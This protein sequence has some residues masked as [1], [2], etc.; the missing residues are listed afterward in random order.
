M[1]SEILKRP[2]QSFVRREGRMT[3][4]QKK[5]FETY[6]NQYGIE[7]G[8]GM[9]D[10]DIVFGR[11]SLRTL[12]IGFGNGDS[13]LEQAQLNSERDFI[14]IEVYRSGI[15]NLLINCEK[16]NV[17]N[18]RVINGD[19]VEVLQQHIFNDSLDRIQ[20]FFPDPWPKERHHKRRLI[21]ENFIDL[22]HEKLMCR[23]QLHLATDWQNYA[24]QMMTV[25]GDAR[26][27]FR[28]IAGNGNF[29]INDG[30]RPKTKFEMRGERLGHGVWDLIFEVK[31]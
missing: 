3:K 20:I 13:L 28:N 11:R 17:T 6:W 8:P 1:R 7:C 23:G 31:K 24:E 30:L 9:I 18:I 15:G 4:A 29:M 2:I 26:A 5:A 25:M 21:K 10:F 12:E 16:Q 22:I 19:A 27:K 14:G